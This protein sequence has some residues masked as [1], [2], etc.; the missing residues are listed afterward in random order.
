MTARLTD[1]PFG[2]TV[3]SAYTDWLAGTKPEA[4]NGPVRKVKKHMIQSVP[5]IAV[6]DDEAEIRALLCDYLTGKGY[7]VTALADGAHELRIHGQDVPVRAAVEKISGL[8]GHA[9][10]TELLRWLS[11]LPPP[12]QTFLTHGEPD[13]ASALA[14]TLRER[15]ESEVIVPKLGESFELD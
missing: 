8:S 2:R 13:S 7:R 5:H 14:E 12:K 9:D 15:W 1:R 11:E 6:V 3:A 4:P 10:R